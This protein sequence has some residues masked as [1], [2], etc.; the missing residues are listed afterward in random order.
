MFNQVMKMWEKKENFHY[1]FFALMLF[2][3]KHQVRNYVINPNRIILTETYDLGNSGSKIAQ[4]SS[5]D[6]RKS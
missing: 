6:I 3:V 4:L 5:M 1:L 2:S